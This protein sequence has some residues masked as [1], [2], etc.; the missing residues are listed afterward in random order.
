MS[1][2]KGPLDIEDATGREGEPIYKVVR[3]ESGLKS[4]LAT[5]YEM[6]LCEEHGGTALGNAQLYRAAP[7]L[8]ETLKAVRR[9]IAH[10]APAEHHIVTLCDA[11][12]AQAEGKE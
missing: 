4:V 3:I 12:I 9:I 2:T 11:A 7:Q 5:C 10:N 1:Y 6:S 8:L